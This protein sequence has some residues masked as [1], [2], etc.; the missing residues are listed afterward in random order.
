MFWFVELENQKFKSPRIKFG[1]CQ[2]ILTGVGHLYVEIL[3]WSPFPSVKH[4]LSF[5][6]TS[7]DSI[8]FLI[9][10]LTEKYPPT[11]SL[12]GYPNVA[13]IYSV[14]LASKDS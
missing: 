2:T 8:S 10:I 5:R 9:E 6:A 3:V 12:S 13:I 1:L 4:K 14:F 7:R 11:A